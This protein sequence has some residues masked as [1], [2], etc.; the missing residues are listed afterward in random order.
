MRLRRETGDF[1]I[2]VNYFPGDPTVNTIRPGLSAEDFAG[3]MVKVVEELS[4]IDSETSEQVTYTQNT[5][6]AVISAT[7]GVGMSGGPAAGTV[8]F[9]T[10][11]YTLTYT[12]ATGV[13]TAVAN[14]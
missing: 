3:E 8:E 2:T 13:I 5:F 11:S 1:Q 6:E 12:K 14:A 4:T 9:V 10:K 7:D